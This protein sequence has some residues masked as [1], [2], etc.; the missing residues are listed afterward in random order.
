MR[1]IININ[2]A[3]IVWTKMGLITST[4]ISTITRFCC[5]AIKQQRRCSGV[6]M[7][8]I[9]ISFGDFCIFVR[10]VGCA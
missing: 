7:H 1:R 4:H 9:E 5:L 2:I 10:L 8:A 6:L 3:K